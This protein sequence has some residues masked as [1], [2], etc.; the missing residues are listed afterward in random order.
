[1]DRGNGLPKGY[2]FVEYRDKDVA[3]SALRNLNKHE[4]LKRELKV[5]FASDNKNGSNLRPEDISNRDDAAEMFLSTFMKGDSM[6]TPVD[7]NAL[8][9]AESRIK[10][11]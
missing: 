6:T 8:E 7:C 4:L 10:G 3:C 1:M 5:D 9:D 2:G 11:Q